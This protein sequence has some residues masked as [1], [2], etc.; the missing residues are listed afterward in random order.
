MIALVILFAGVMT[1]SGIWSMVEAYYS[2]QTKKGTF[3]FI[4]GDAA[5]WMG[6]L[7][8]CMGMWMVTLVIP[9]LAFAKKWIGFWVVM[10]AISLVMVLK[11]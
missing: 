4:E 10:F 3:V 11:S 9:N 6:F 5:R 7:Q 1:A 2:G 8:I